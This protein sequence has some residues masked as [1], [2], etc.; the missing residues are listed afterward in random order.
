MAHACEWN[1]SMTEATDCLLQIQLAGGTYV[2]IEWVEGKGS[3]N[4]GNQNAGCKH[5]K[6]GNMFRHE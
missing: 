4:R 1:E 2:L 6:L 5:I 3:N